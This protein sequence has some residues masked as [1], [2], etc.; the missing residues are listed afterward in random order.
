MTQH[1]VPQDTVEDQQIMRRLM[2]VIAGFMAATAAMA[3]VV[4]AFAS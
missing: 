4:A 1:I 3:L 2:I